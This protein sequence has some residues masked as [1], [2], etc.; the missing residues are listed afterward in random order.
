MTKLERMQR[1][2]EARLTRQQKNNWTPIYLGPI[3]DKATK[4]FNELKCEH[5]K[6]RQ[7]RK[8]RIGGKSSRTRKAENR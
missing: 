7:L 5:L 8:R 6:L 1:D 2:Y 4:D 3:N